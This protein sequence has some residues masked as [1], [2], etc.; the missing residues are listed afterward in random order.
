MRSAIVCLVAT[1]TYAIMFR[2]HTYR[3]TCT[4]IQRLYTHRRSL[5]TSNNRHTY[6]TLTTGDLLHIS[7]SSFTRILQRE[8]INTH[9]PR[10]IIREHVFSCTCHN[11][12][13]N[14]ALGKTHAPD[15]MSGVQPFSFDNVNIVQHM[16]VSNMSFD[17][18]NSCLHFI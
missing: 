14:I 7:H 10:Q 2:Q 8:R 18:A 17:S 11:N 9:T 13:Y 3:H 6:A 12:A 1:R 15:R 5:A 4:F 16:Q